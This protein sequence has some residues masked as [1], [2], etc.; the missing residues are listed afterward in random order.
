MGLFRT[1]VMSRMD[2]VIVSVLWMEISVASV[3][4]TR[5][6]SHPV[7]DV[8]RVTAAHLVRLTYS[9]QRAGSACADPGWR[10]R[11]VKPVS[12]GTLD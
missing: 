9:V 10:E 8:S 7:W 6:T 2:S 4:Q 5:T 11:N 3:R 12:M 1:C